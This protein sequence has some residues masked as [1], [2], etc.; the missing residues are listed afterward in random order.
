MADITENT[1][2][3]YLGPEFQQH[4]MWQLLVEPEFAE[5]IIPDIAIEYFDDPN[6]RRLF[7]I[8]LEYF[9][10]FQKVPNLQNQSIH[11]AI[12]KYK[13]PNNVIEEESLFAVIKRIELWNERIINKQMLYDGDVIQKSTNSFIKQQEYRKL[14][15]GIIDKVKNGEIKS[16][17]VIAAIEEKFQKITH[18]GEDE[19]DCEEV[20]EGIEKALRK[21]FRQPIPT[22]IGVIDSL[23]G[24]GLGKGEIGL[25]L[26]P[27]GVGKALPNSHKVL[28]PNGWVENGTL[29]VNDYIF[30]SDG[31][32]QKI[33][34]VY[35]QG[36][37]KIYKVTFSDQTISYC[38]VEHLWAVNSFKQRNQ[39][40][41][42]NGKTLSIPDHTF[43]ILKTSEIMEDIKIKNNLNYRLPNVLPI[44]FNKLEVKIDPYI[45]GVLLGDGC[46]TRK[47]QPHI[48]TSD[49]F[50]V[51][52]ICNLE[53]NVIVHEY[54]G[55]KE[56]YKKLYRISLINSRNVLETELNLYGTDSTNKFIPNIYLYNCIEYR[57]K[58]LQGL[59]DSDGGVGKNHSIIYSTVSK[60]LSKNVRELVLSLGG[61]CRINEKIKS[62]NKNGV[63]VLG[64]KN[65]CLTISFPN[66][67]IKPCTLPTK[68]DRIVIRD[69]YEYNKFIKNI[70]YSHEEDATCIYVENNDH[71][72]IIDDYI[73]THNT[74]ALTIIANTAYEQEK[75]VAQIIIED[76]KEQIKRKHYTIWAKSALSKLDDEDENARVFK[77]ATEKAE[78]LEGKGR[79]LIKQFSQENTTMLDIKNWMIGYQKKYG[80]KFDILVIDYL[81]CLES[82]KKSPDRNEA[83]LQIVKSFEALASDFDIP[84]WSAIQTNRSG[85]GAAIV[86][87]QQ[88]G[89]NI[90]RIQKA[91]FFMSVAKTP[92][93]QDA[94]FANI[95]ILKAR[96]A[97]DGQTFEDCIFNNDTM[98]II[99]TD[100]KYP[101][102][103][104]LKHYDEN[105]V[106]K[107]ESTANKM[108]VV[109]SQLAEDSKNAVDVVNLSSTEINRLLQNNSEFEIE[110]N[111]VK[112]NETVIKTN[113]DEPIVKTEPIKAESSDFIEQM[114]RE[115]EGEIHG[116]PVKQIENIHISTTRI[117]LNQNEIKQIIDIANEA[118]LEINGVVEE[119]NEEII[120]PEVIFH[121]EQIKSDEKKEPFEWNGESGSTI[122]E[123]INQPEVKLEDIK[124]SLD[125]TKFVPPGVF[126]KEIDNNIVEK[127][128]EIKE[129][130]L[131]IKPLIERTNK[132]INIK[133][134]ENKLLIDPD[135][136]QENEKN[137]FN[138]L[139]KARQNQRVIK[140]D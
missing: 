98:Q 82:H 125:L 18:I 65:Y 75:N 58:L 93:Q 128:R 31:K 89:G 78:S 99:I 134:L 24:G 97:K 54:E 52:K 62:Y 14:A 4:L 38:D 116:V 25:I 9:K 96:F 39:K 88:T 17:Y 106:N 100:S 71:L 81:D 133:E 118:I 8:I 94:N 119:L 60:E 113:T 42:I 114:R 95:S 103:N 84:A 101:V 124:K 72:Y 49:L 120:H 13:T 108:H 111:T 35:P 45:M 83:E 69:K 79:L 53:K 68:L 61:T 44:Q 55:R 3:S 27:S 131:T 50:I 85:F 32:K 135:E 122:N 77:I 48:I 26:T 91:H 10:E 86:G 5:K 87:A 123:I 37:R 29:K 23:T 117:D 11:Q 105:D 132:N 19:D 130:N 41:N 107:V 51:D 64:K 7:L 2:S 140:D 121:E 20:I 73:L 16:K 56:N 12:N 59:I 102:K 112:E 21:E 104:K 43:Q 76:T 137:V 110:Q 34:A 129:E 57:E 136:P 28:T 127:N 47:N 15:E 139:N 30:G 40:T 80:F 6:L 63:K 66:N 109:V 33:L 126:V 74:T 46:L 67:G 1:L 115:I 36:K 22:G 92:A 138:I 70:E 90:K